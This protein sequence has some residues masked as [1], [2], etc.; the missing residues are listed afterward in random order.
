ML[1]KEKTTFINILKGN[2]HNKL[3]FRTKTYKKAERHRTCTVRGYPAFLAI[4]NA[5]RV[6]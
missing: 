1:V 2:K 5:S 4:Q 6:R 3:C